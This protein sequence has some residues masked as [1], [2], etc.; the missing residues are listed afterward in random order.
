M[1]V[2]RSYMA[3]VFI[4]TQDSLGNH[5]IPLSRTFTN[6]SCDLLGILSV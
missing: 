3:L 5:T 1:A 4:R 6:M 2:D